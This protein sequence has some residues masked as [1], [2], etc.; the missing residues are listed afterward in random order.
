MVFKRSVSSFQFSVFLRLC[1]KLLNH[2]YFQRSIAGLPGIPGSNGMPG[3]PGVPGP[4]G[5]QGRDG[6]KGGIGNK[7]SQGMPGPR[8]DRGREGPPAFISIEL[9]IP[10]IALI[11]TKDP[12]VS[13]E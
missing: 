13:L 1:I 11:M 3:M 2:L 7:G 6:T 10:P 8:G 4:Q 5:I 12:Q 9:E